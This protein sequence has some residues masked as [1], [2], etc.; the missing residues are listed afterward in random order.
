MAHLAPDILTRSLTPQNLTPRESLRQAL[1]LLESAGWTVKGGVLQKEGVPFEFE[2]LI[3]SMSAP[4]W[5]RVILP[6]IG[7]LKRLGIQAKIKT[8]DV[9]NYQTRLEKFDYDMIIF[10]WGQ[11]LSPGSEQAEY[12]GSKAADTFGSY[13]YSGIKNPAVDALVQ[14][15]IKARNKESLQ[16]AMHA[17]DRVLLSEYIVIPHWSSSVHRCLYRNTL[18]HPSKTPLSGVDI[19]TWWKK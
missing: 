11:S 10:I 9:L 8:V 13:N 18:D 3:D 5:E 19:S 2:I 17:L 4:T 7:Q 1:D 12:W 15:V 6:Y 14:K 16:T